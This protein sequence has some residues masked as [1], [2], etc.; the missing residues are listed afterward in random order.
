MGSTV[1]AG[2]KDEL[3]AATLLDVI[4]ELRQNREVSEKIAIT[5]VQILEGQTQLGEQM[6][7]AVARANRHERKQAESEGKIR[8]LESAKDSHEK[9]IS[10]L[11]KSS[12][13]PARTG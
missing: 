1:T 10:A 9:R 12:S 7:A 3:A 13:R 2:T 6:Q 4:T 8:V 5:L 11:E